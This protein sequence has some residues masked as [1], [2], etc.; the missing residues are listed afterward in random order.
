MVVGQENSSGVLS[1]ETSHT[2]VQRSPTDT[3]ERPKSRTGL[4]NG[5]LTANRSASPT[6]VIEMAAVELPAITKAGN[7]PVPAADGAVRAR[8]RTSRYKKAYSED[9]PS[10]REEDGAEEGEDNEDG[11]D[12]TKLQRSASERRTPDSQ[13][14]SQPTT[15]TTTTTTTTN[16]NRHTEYNKHSNPAL[17]SA[18][19]R[20]S[21]GQEARCPDNVLSDSYTSDSAIQNSAI[22]REKL[23]AAAAAAAKDTEEM[24][25]QEEE[26][27]EEQEVSVSDWC[28]CVFMCACVFVCVFTFRGFSVYVS[29][30][31]VRFSVCMSDCL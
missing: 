1:T 8:E 23:A 6:D 13:N 17:S 11:A 20:Q 22:Q 3:G 27:D 19:N 9:I 26:E 5:Y 2:D 12:R 24:R 30:V 15:T 31:Y 4:R 28:V 10:L 18:D 21:S 16:T 14:T 25:K 7:G 29:C